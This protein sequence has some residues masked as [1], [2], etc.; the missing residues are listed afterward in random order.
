VAFHNI[1]G[2]GM[3]GMITS[4]RYKEKEAMKLTGTQKISRHIVTVYK[5]SRV[6]K[7]K[8][9]EE[10]EAEKK[11]INNKRK[12]SKASRKARRKSK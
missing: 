9:S 11:R 8:T 1:Y 3:E 7:D 10:L 4:H 6:K 5:E 12:K 2:E